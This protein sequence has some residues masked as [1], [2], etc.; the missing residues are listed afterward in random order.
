MVYLIVL[1][2]LLLLTVHYDINGKTKYR[3][4]WYSA[5]TII[6]IL[7]AGLRFRLGDDTLNYIYMF[8]YDTPNL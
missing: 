2:I 6:L 7:I 1:V 8:Y 5:I 3:N 4:Q